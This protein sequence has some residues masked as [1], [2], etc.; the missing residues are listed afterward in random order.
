MNNSTPQSYSTVCPFIMVDNVEKQMDFL[1]IVFSAE[2]KGNLKNAEGISVHGEVTIGSCVIMLGKGSADLQSQP[3]MNYVYVNDANSV[4][5]KALQ[6]GVT[7][8]YAPDDKFY[9]IREAGFRDLHNNTW[10]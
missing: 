3:S 2:I 5:E 7:S 8:M 10:L 6:P 4:Y 1:H 9:R